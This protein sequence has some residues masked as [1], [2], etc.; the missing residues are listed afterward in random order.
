MII[1]LISPIKVI[2]Y[3]ILILVLQQF[4]GLYLGP[5]I[6]GDSTGL[7]P[8]WIIF[9]IT[10]GGAMMGLFGMFL[11]VPCV[12]V[13]SYLMGEWIDKRLDKKEIDHD[14]LKI[15]PGKRSESGWKQSKKYKKKRWSQNGI[16]IKQKKKRKILSRILKKTTGIRKSRIGKGQLSCGCEFF[17]NLY[18]FTRNL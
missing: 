3:L 2:V 14:S 9:A 15:Q 1:L 10:I 16:F 6:L 13:I 8:I 4:D 5:K 7:R 12:A 18:Y 11:G 17:H